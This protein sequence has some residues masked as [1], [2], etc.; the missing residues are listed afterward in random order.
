M[1]WGV[2]PFSD[3]GFWGNTEGGTTILLIAALFLYGFGGLFGVS[4][5]TPV[6]LEPYLDK[7]DS[8]SIARL[9]TPVEGGT[10]AAVI[11]NFEGHRLTADST[12]MEI[13]KP[14][15]GKPRNIVED[16][17]EPYKYSLSEVKNKNQKI[18]G[19]LMIREGRLAGQY[20][21]ND[22]SLDLTGE[23]PKLP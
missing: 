12:N 13:E 16:D 9:T 4:P 5:V 17:V 11:I 6:K 15:R 22:A 10:I 1:G 23:E 14:Y 2:G 3:N 8:L 20:L 21:D 18:L 7:V 19:Y